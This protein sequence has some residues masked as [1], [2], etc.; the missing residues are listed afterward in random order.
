MTESVGNVSFDD[1][2]QQPAAQAAMNAG[3]A[4]KCPEN[5]AGRCTAARGCFTK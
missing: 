1:S 4:V 3:I 5:V 2:V